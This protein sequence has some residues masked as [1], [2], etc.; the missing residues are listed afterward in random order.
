MPQK[1][2]PEHQSLNYLNNILAKIEA[3]A[4]GG[5]EAIM[6]DVHGNLSEVQ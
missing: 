1:Q 5:D 3:N 6:F 2:C 4:K